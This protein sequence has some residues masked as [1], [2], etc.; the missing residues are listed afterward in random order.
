MI[1]FVLFVIQTI[2]SMT[3]ILH[4]CVMNIHSLE[5]EFDVRSNEETFTYLKNH[6]WKQ[7]FLLG[8]HGKKRNYIF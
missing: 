2:L 8:K 5:N 3:S 6:H 7:V 1:D 4:V